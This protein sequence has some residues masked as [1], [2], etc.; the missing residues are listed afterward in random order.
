[1]AVLLMMICTKYSNNAE[2]KITST[3]RV[4]RKGMWESGGYQRSVCRK[5]ETLEREKK[6][7][8]VDLIA[9][10]L[11]PLVDDDDDDDD[12]DGD[13]EGEDIDDSMPLKQPPQHPTHNNPP[14]HLPSSNSSI[15]LQ[16]RLPSLTRPTRTTA[17]RLS[18]R[19]RG[20]NKRIRRNSRRFPIRIRRRQQ[21][22]TGNLA[23]A[24]RIRGDEG[25]AA[26]ISLGADFSWGR[27][28][29]GGGGD[30]GGAALGVSRGADDGGAGFCCGDGAALGV[31]GGVGY[32]DGGG[33]LGED[34]GGL[35]DGLALGVGGGLGDG[36]DYGAVLGGGALWGSWGS[37]GGWLLRGRGA[38]GVAGLRRW[39]G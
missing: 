12:D 38:L 19:A 13:I 23:A 30:G 8:F 33:D 2:T 22:H 39:V 21:L 25:R 26:G 34:G 5:N 28:E 37:S 9:P 10:P 6:R 3:R 31:G 14:R 1:M 20:V 7:E 24:R 27:C 36:D 16:P 35:D 18:R 4:Y 32:G 11:I 17:I 29:V 15:R